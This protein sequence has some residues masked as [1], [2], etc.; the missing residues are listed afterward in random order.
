MKRVA[1][2]LALL[3]LPGLL[4]AQGQNIAGT[5]VNATTGQALPRRAVTLIQLQGNMQTVAKTTTDEQGHYRF[6]QSGPGPFMVEADYNQVRYFAKVAAGQSETNVQVYDVSGDTTLVKVDAEIMVLQPDAGQ[7]AV[8][9]EYRIENGTQPPKT[10]NANQGLFRFRVP[11]G[12]QVDMVRVVGPGEMPLALQA[13]PTAQHDVYAV[14]SPLRPGETKVQVSY[15]VPYPALKAALAETPVF[16]PNHFEVYVPT[17]MQF[18][19][20]GLTQVG[21]QD[22]Y[23]VF[24]VAAG[25]VAATLHFNV[26]GDAPMPAAPA[27]PGA[28]NADGSPTGATGSVPGSDANSAAP[29]QPTAAPAAVP[30]PTFVERNLWVILAMLGLGAAGGFGM[31]LAQPKPAKAEDYG[32]PLVLALPRPAALPPHD[33][34]AA[35]P[36]AAGNSSAPTAPLVDSLL[37]LKDDLF[38]LEVRRHTR[39]IGEA[40]YLHQR[41]QISERMDRLAGH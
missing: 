7:L 9:N 15:R 40:E 36:F 30:A 29:T 41:A 1:L 28:A 33:A 13:A 14:N 27:D 16:A 25:P 5:V 20:A 6:S 17:P 24:G 19:G 34:S 11:T 21:A 37:Q 18:D 35:M 38:L 3:L 22:G 2:S 23:K 12:A 4:Q 31:L 8:V 32:E 26:S 10:L 39:N